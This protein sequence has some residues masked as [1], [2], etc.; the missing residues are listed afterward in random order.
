MPAHYNTVRM[1][2]LLKLHDT[3]TTI[4]LRRYLGR[5]VIKGA[6]VIGAYYVPFGS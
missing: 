2:S 6:V 1:N 4:Q 5:V 3:Y